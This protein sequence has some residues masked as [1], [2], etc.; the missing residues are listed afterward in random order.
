MLSALPTT[1]FTQGLKLALHHKPEIDKLDPEAGPAEI[2]AALSLEGPFSGTR[3]AID[4]SWMVEFLDWQNLMALSAQDRR[5]SK[6]RDST[7]K[8]QDEDGTDGTDDAKPLAMSG[9]RLQ[10]R[11]KITITGGPDNDNNED[12]NNRVTSYPRL[13]SQKL[14]NKH[15][16]PALRAPIEAR[17]KRSSQESSTLVD[18][19]TAL[20][21]ATDQNPPAVRVSIADLLNVKNDNYLSG[22]RRFLPP[23]KG[24]SEETI[25]LNLSLIKKL[26]L[27][28][29]DLSLFRV[30]DLEHYAELANE[31]FG[32][33]YSSE[34]AHKHLEIFQMLPTF[35]RNLA[36]TSARS[37]AANVHS[38]HSNFAICLF[39]EY[40][41]ECKTHILEVFD[42]PHFVSDDQ[43]S[44]GDAIK[45]LADND[46][47]DPTSLSLHFAKFSL[48]DL[49]EMLSLTQETLL[50]KAREDTAVDLDRIFT[51]YR[52][53]TD[54]SLN[55]V[56][57]GAYIS[58]LIN[59]V[60]SGRAGFQ[61]TR[62]YC[63]W[64]LKFAKEIERG[65]AEVGRFKGLLGSADYE[66]LKLA[67][68]YAYATLRAQL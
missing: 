15:G 7:G 58:G 39:D 31:Y 20:P 66:E 56:F 36:R 21:R 42:L 22:T 62:N 18:A 47:V 17:E 33:T 29:D 24:N 8:A 43:M 2:A 37:K 11:R 27:Q 41:E 23:F 1:P 19:K 53:D 10:K 51:K 38:D 16:P 14:I 40:P 3:L 54:V 68:V 4:G 45:T 32:G 60:I 48:D 6:A 61:L 64:V 9:R 55:S 13:Q 52:I 46:D 5:S 44:L 26:A 63:L 30:A 34:F 57:P 49:D 12:D 65:F 35:S 25:G 59:H 28:D 67:I 50:S